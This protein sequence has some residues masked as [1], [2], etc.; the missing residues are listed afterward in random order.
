LNYQSVLQIVEEIL[1]G[2]DPKTQKGS[3]DGILDEIEAYSRADEEQNRKTLH[4]HYLIWVKGFSDIRDALFDNDADKREA[5][6]AKFYE[7]INKIMCASYYKNKDWIIE[8]ECNG[9]TKKAKVEDVYQERGPQILRDARHQEDCHEV[10]GK[11]MECTSCGEEVSTQEIINM[12]LREWHQNAVRDKQTSAESDLEFPLRNE[13]LA[14]AAYRWPFDKDN[15]KLSDDTFWGN[16]DVRSILQIS[17]ENEH[18]A[19]HGPRCFKK[20]NECTSGSFPQAYCPD[21]C[22]HEDLSGGQEELHIRHLLN[23]SKTHSPPWMILPKR[24]LG[25]QYLNTHNPIISGVI[26]SNTNVL[27]G[28]ISQA[29]YT[30]LYSSKSTQKEDREKYVTIGKKLTRRMKRLEMERQTNPDEYEE[31]ENG[32]FVNGLGMML[33]AMIANTS[34]DVVSS[35][36]SHLLVAQKGKRFTF[37]HEPKHLLL[38]QLEAQLDN[39]DEVQFTLR[40][41]NR[42]TNEGKVVQWPDSSANDYLDRPVELEDC[43]AYYYTER[44]EKKFFAW[45]EMD[46]DEEDTV[47][48]RSHGYRFPTKHPGHEFAYMHPLKVPAVVVVSYPEG[49]LCLLKELELT[50]DNPSQLAQEKR[51]DYAKV[52]LMM[53]Y[54]FRT[55]DDL[56]TNGSYWTT[57]DRERKGYFSGTKTVFW[58]EGFKILQNI[59]DRMSIQLS[60]SRVRARDP[61]QLRSVVKSDDKEKKKKK[62][63]G[64]QAPD[65]SFYDDSDDESYDDSD[66][67]DGEKYADRD[68]RTHDHLVN[69]LKKVRVKD[70]CISARI[71]SL[72]ASLIQTDDESTTSNAHGGDDGNNSQEGEMNT[73]SYY[74]NRD[75]PT[76]IKLITGS[77]IG[78]SAS[79]DDIYENGEDIIPVDNDEGEDKIAGSGVDV[80]YNIP[81]VTQDD[82]MQN[83]Q[84]SHRSTTNYIFAFINTLY[85]HLCIYNINITGN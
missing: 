85:S 32:Q 63:D 67:E 53:F 75:Y 44:Y 14:I 34:R 47:V 66:M 71:T 19:L 2:W 20:G 74:E 51:E 72:D 18:R 24:P 22:I 5:A 82:S 33:S 43:C 80:D 11:I 42:S 83:E 30:T 36:M 78:G 28:D 40:R 49:K 15:G 27:M 64:D 12:T 56:L 59:E 45:K 61:V 57:F 21:T 29:F 69:R 65:I 60:K 38:T 37:S 9:E 13:R 50:S 54:P 10:N 41:T 70:K 39:D 46:N 52:A 6:R 84:V 58:A 16:D 55:L 76:L 68:R 17:A 3:P 79:Y 23:G 31:D 81:T 1:L 62:N 26:S 73:N 25:C 7:Y 77:L 8:H 4:G 35:T 48:S